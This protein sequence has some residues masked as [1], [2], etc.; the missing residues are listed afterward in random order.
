[1]STSHHGG[2]LSNLAAASEANPL[3]E[4]APDVSR[5]RSLKDGELH[6]ESGFGFRSAAEVEDGKQLLQVGVHMA[7]ALER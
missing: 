3:P 7:E 4:V 2:I 1:V 6:L 5:I